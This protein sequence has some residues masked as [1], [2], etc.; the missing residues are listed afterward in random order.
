[1][2]NAKLALLIWAGVTLLSFGGVFIDKLEL[3]SH[4]RVQ[5]LALSIILAVIVSLREPRRMQAAA[6]ALCL[7]NAWP[8][9]QHLE[10][11]APRT[12]I[13]ETDTD[14]G[15]TVLTANLHG[16]KV[17]RPGLDA[18]LKTATPD[19]ALFTELTPDSEAL[20]RAGLPDHGFAWIGEP[21]G[22][23][24]SLIALKGQAPTPE[25]HYASTDQY[26]PW[27]QV[28]ACFETC[29]SIIAL[30]AAPPPGL[31]DKPW[32]DD[33]YAQIREL[34]AT[35]GKPDLLLGDLNT[36]PW[37]PVFSALIRDTGL[38]DTAPEFELG[39]T[40][41]FG[42]PGLGIRIDHILIGADYTVSDYRVGP[43]LNSDH[44]PVL[45]RIAPVS[46]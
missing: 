6:L 29:L 22:L 5:F 42:I 27:A 45:A 40:W 34:S 4:W 11:T 23:F 10:R 37:S 46:R 35:E 33:G 28:E 43:D 19:I 20:I 24:S 7:L 26:F 41:P 38:R 31:T 36:S 14:K 16:H 13:T 15:L 8:L 21:Y 12:P 3:M 32:R 1:M 44:R 9:A 18:L 25:I 39:T 2:S 17:D 30:H